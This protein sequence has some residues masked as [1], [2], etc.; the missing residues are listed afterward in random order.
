VLIRVR[1]GGPFL[2]LIA[3]GRLVDL[4]GAKVLAAIQPCQAAE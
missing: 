4:L 3:D 2:P 1:E